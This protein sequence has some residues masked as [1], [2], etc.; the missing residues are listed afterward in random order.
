MLG[1]EDL[2]DHYDL[3]K[4]PTLGVMTVNLHPVLRSDCEALAGKSTINRLEHSPNR[5]AEKYHSI[6]CDG[7]QVDA[8]LVELFLEAHER[9]RARSCSISTIPTSRC[10]ALRKAGSS[11]VIMTRTATCRSTCSAAGICCWPGSGV[12]MLPAAMARSKR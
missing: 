2:N 10:T 11:M 4:D 9:G 6:D 3:R 7:P 12:R 1:D 5:H 8:L